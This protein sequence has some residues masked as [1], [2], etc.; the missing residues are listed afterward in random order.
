MARFIFITFYAP[1]KKMRE[2]LLNK[3][4][5]NWIVILYSI[6]IERVQNSSAFDDTQHTTKCFLFYT[7]DALTHNP[8]RQ[9]TF[10]QRNA[11][12]R[13]CNHCYHENATISS[14]RTVGVGL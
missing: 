5:P 1:T 13:L 6:N 7:I 11:A 14:V 4:K 12:V 8:Q 2:K 10:V 3:R 9:A